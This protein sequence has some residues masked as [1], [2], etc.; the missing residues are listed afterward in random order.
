MTGARGNELQLNMWLPSWLRRPYVFISYAHADRDRVGYVVS[1]LERRRI[2]CWMDRHLQPG[3]YFNQTIRDRIR[4]SCVVLWFAS[5]NS[6]DREYVRLEIDQAV[7]H[8]HE[9]IPV[10][11]D[12]IDPRILPLP[13]SQICA[14]VHGVAYFDTSRKEEQFVGLEETLL[15]RLKAARRKQLAALGLAIASVVA[16][17]SLAVIANEP[18]PAPIPVNSPSP[19]STMAKTPKRPA[20]DM[21]RVPAGELYKGAWDQSLTAKLLKKYGGDKPANRAILYDTILAAPRDVSLASFDL[22][23]FEASNSLYREFLR[24]LGTKHTWCN[25]SEP[26]GKRHTSLFAD[27]KDSSDSRQPIVGIDWFDA[28]SFC[29]WAHKRLPTEDEWEFAARGRERRVYPWGQVFDQ[30]KFLAANPAMASI[31]V[32]QM[33]LTQAGLP[34]G[35][36][37]NVSEWTS[38]I[39][40]S[41]RMIAKGAAWNQVDG[42]IFALTFARQLYDPASRLRGLGVRCARDPSPA[43]SEGMLRIQGGT[44]RLGGDSSPVLDLMRNASVWLIAQTGV[45]TMPPFRV[46]RHEVTNA[47]YATFLDSIGTTGDAAFAHPD[48]PR[49][50]DHTPKF[51]SDA[52]T[53]QRDLPVVGVDWFDAYA[54]ARWAGKRLPTSDEWEYAARA[55]TKQLYP[56]GDEFDPDRCV[57]AELGASGPVAAASSSVRGASPFGILHLAGNAQEWT[58]DEGPGGN[59]ERMV[60]RGGGW[61][62]LCRVNGLTFLRETTAPR[63]LRDHE[64]GLRCVDDDSS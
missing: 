58:A 36:D 42:D 59:R 34:V 5:A 63:T 25:A 28:F 49:Q 46:D 32:E 29:Q 24:Q 35:L 60:I 1:L 44:T 47:E 10:F 48:Q 26:A 20:D 57:A 37:G 53:S 7:A 13:F 8:S 41:G 17:L 61:S 15:Q 40:P 18:E 38:S 62:Q 23:T 27:E 54:Y 50:K 3:S 45:V 55:S 16:L 19:A 31:P 12:E 56:W 14:Q 22:D 51:W 43:R 52:K 2:T 33:P 9:V 6:H 4:N 64:L 21:V 30:Q 11:L 39:H